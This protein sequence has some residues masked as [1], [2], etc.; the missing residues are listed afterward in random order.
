MRSFITSTDLSFGVLISSEDYRIL[1]D[2]LETDR[3]DDGLLFV[4]FRLFYLL[5]YL[6]FVLRSPD[7]GV[8]ISS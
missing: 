4:E 6:S 2:Y 1:R 5:S 3:T 7:A 8:R